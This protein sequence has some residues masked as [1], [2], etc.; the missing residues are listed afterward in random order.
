MRTGAE[1]ET[2]LGL[3]QDYL[4][5]LLYISGLDIL[6]E[7]CPTSPF[8]MPLRGLFHTRVQRAELGVIR[9]IWPHSV[10]VIII[11]GG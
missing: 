6:T 11:L 5:L 7:E 4:D 2:W 10:T 3:T 8:I 1:K 9:S